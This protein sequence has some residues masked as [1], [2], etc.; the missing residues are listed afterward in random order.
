MNN[1][2]VNVSI[3]TL[4]IVIAQYLHRSKLRIGWS[5]LQKRR[6]ANRN[7]VRRLWCTRM[8]LN[9]PLVLFCDNS[10][11]KSG[12]VS[13]CMYE[14]SYPLLLYMYN[15]VAYC[16]KARQRPRFYSKRAQRYCVEKLKRRRR[17]EERRN[18]SAN[19]TLRSLAHPRTIRGRNVRP[20][21]SQAHSTDL[22]AI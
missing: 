7:F 1:L 13:I 17:R 22:D 15:R 16:V 5:L 9:G 11:R 10:V 12:T 3:A 14:R 20:H 6:A 21:F 8:F 19:E 2:L 4:S 18:D